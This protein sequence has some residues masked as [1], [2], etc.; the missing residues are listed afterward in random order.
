[1]SKISEISFFGKINFVKKET[2]NENKSNVE[3]S[4]STNTAK[5]LSKTGLDNIKKEINDVKTFVLNSIH[6][7]DKQSQQLPE[8]KMP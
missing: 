4:T 2:S 6:M 8:L 5:S 7:G 1:M 3:I